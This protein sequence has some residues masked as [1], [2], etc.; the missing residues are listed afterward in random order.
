VKLVG[1][2][3]SVAG[4]TYIDTTAAAFASPALANMQILASGGTQV[5]PVEPL[6]IPPGWG[7]LLWGNAQ[8]TSFACQFEWYEEPST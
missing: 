2:V 8:N 4:L 6:V 1:G 3:N 7:V 5:K